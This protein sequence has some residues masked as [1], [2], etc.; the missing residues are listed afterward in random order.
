MTNR[1]YE[2]DKTLDELQA[3]REREFDMLRHG[4]VA[5]WEGPGAPLRNLGAHPEDEGFDGDA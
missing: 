3:E 5:T 1:Y 2:P 4:G